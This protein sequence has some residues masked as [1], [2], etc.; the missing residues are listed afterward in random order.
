M[1][2]LSAQFRLTLDGEKLK[3]RSRKTRTNARFSKSD[4]SDPGPWVTESVEL[5]LPTTDAWPVSSTRMTGGGCNRTYT[6][7]AS[8]SMVVG[9]HKNA[10]TMARLA[11]A[12]KAPSCS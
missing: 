8:A 2:R 3:S 10:R 7:K 12:R 11:Y 5:F 4:G 6:A 9:T 1:F